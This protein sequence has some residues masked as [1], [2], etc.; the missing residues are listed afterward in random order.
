[1]SETRLWNI[2]DIPTSIDTWKSIASWP[3]SDITYLVLDVPDEPV[4]PAEPQT[5]LWNILD[6]P[7]SIDTWKWLA[8]W[9]DSD[10]TY[11]VLTVPDEPVEP[12]K[13]LVWDTPPEIIYEYGIDR[14][15]I[16]LEDCVA[17][18]WNGLTSVTETNTIDNTSIYYEG[19]KISELLSTG[20]FTGTIKAITYPDE[21]IELEGLG[22]IVSGVYVGDQKPK[23]FNLSYRTLVGNGLDTDVGYKIHILYNVLATSS[24]KEYDTVSDQINLTEF[25]WTINAIPEVLSGFRPTAHV[26]IDTT[27]AKPLVVTGIE[28]KLYGTDTEEACLP[29]F[30]ELMEYIAIIAY[31]IV[32]IDNGDGSWTMETDLPDI[33]SINGENIFTINSPGAHV[34]DTDSYTLSSVE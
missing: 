21:V 25:E 13:K 7:T 12:S 14:G 27:K 10:I 6:I 30:S 24:D 34:V 29:S 33:I 9:P 31:S 22:T 1:M 2:L 11:L 23:S 17:I 32:V 4:E 5:R 16:Y 20:A 3:D 18:P 26:I 19:V 28:E 8:S 15:V